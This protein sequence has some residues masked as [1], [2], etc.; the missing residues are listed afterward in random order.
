MSTTHSTLSALVGYGLVT[1][2]L[3]GVN[4]LMVIG[5]I[6]GWLL[7]LALG[8]SG[9]YVLTKAVSHIKENNSKDHDKF[10]RY[11]SRLLIFSTFLLQ[12]SRWGND[13][14]NAAGLLYGLFDPLVSRFVCA[15][16]MAFGLIVLGRIVVG[17]VGIRMVR[18]LPSA[19][20][21]AQIVSTAIIFPFAYVGVPLSG[22]HVLISS[23][24]GTGM[25][26]KARVNTRVT[27]VFSVAWMLSFIC[28]GILAVAIVSV[29]RLF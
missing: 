10:E 14:G 24:I 2:G 19:A 5:I 16:A 28:P 29:V 27:G 25:A 17:S 4:G 12:F 3:G 7:S 9:A 8:F 22:T 15:L 11:F 18:L 1:I 26:T 6:Q 20:F 13:V 21:V 23:M